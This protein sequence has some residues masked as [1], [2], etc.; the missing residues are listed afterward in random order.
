MQLFSTLSLKSHRVG[1]LIII[2]FISFSFVAIRVAKGLRHY[3]RVGRDL[4]R[5]FGKQ[6]VVLGIGAVLA[7]V[8]WDRR[9]FL[10]DYIR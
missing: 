2:I 5:I 7:K 10:A 9:E 3:Y 1:V 8:A 6:L 4:W